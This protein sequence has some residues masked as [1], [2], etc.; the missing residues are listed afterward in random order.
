LGLGDIG[1]K[2]HHPFYLWSH[3]ITDFI[4]DGLFFHHYTCFR[5]ILEGILLMAISDY[6]CRKKSLIVIQIIVAL[7]FLLIIFGGKH[8]QLLMVGVGC[9]GFLYGA[10]FPMYAACVR[11]YFPRKITGTV[12]GL[13]SI[14]YGVGIMASPV[15][16]YHRN[17]SIVFRIRGFCC[18][19]CCPYHLIFKGVEKLREKGD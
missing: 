5:G 19:H 16:G 18:L 10:I 11:D 4:S 14:F 2:F 7:S 8:I 15:G 6:I 12:L 1:V 13:M 17:L 9:F 3:S